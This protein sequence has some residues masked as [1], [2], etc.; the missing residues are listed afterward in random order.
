MKTN[1]N[2]E[3]LLRRQLNVNLDIDSNKHHIYCDIDETITPFESNNIFTQNDKFYTITKDN[4][5]IEI[6]KIPLAIQPL[7]N[8]K[9][10]FVLH[11]NYYRPKTNVLYDDINFYAIE[12]NK[13][14]KVGY[15]LSKVY[16]KNKFMQ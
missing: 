4:T 10:Y 3:P 2:T 6:Y 5:I 7:D 12:N 14:I 15:V 1:I 8:K 16:S 11:N 9:D 13:L